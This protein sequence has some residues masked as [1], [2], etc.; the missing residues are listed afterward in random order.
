ML[1]LHG[2]QA[3]IIVGDQLAFF[4]RFAEKFNAVV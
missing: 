2:I 3:M 1:I 4:E